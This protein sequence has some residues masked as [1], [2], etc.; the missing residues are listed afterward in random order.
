VIGLPRV[1]RLSTGG[2]DL[3][4]AVDITINIMNIKTDGSGTP[5]RAV[6]AFL[7]VVSPLR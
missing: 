7:V 4:C 2:A 5:T 1:A 3:K 6:G